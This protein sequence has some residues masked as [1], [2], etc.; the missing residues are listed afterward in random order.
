MVC[1]TARDMQR[2]ARFLGRGW[3]RFELSVA[4]YDQTDWIFFRLG[5]RALPVRRRRRCDLFAR[6]DE[7]PAGLR[8][9]EHL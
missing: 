3:L 6:R 5:Q 2:C 4:W 9:S 1:K 7:G 8:S